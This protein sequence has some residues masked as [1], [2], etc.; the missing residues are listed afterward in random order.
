MYRDTEKVP[1]ELQEYINKDTFEKSRKYQCDKSRFGFFSGFYSQ[2]ESSV[3]SI[4][5]T[6]TKFR[7]YLK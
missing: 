3:S 7:M 6:N 2:I 4:I 1:E 5:L